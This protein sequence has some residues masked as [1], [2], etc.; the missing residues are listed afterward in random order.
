LE[1]SLYWDKSLLAA[2]MMTS[3]DLISKQWTKWRRLLVY[4]VS[5]ISFLVCPVSQISF[6]VLHNKGFLACSVLTQRQTCTNSFLSFVLC[7]LSTTSN[8]IHLV[9][10]LTEYLQIA[11][12]ALRSRSSVPSWYVLKKHS[13]KLAVVPNTVW[14]HEDMVLKTIS[15][16]VGW[17]MTVTSTDG[18]HRHTSITYRF[19]PHD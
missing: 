11:V 3:M 17:M 5:K 16:G 1:T 2:L 12:L 18:R 13:I 14:Y 15:S 10:L 6:T 4:T 19:Y 9:L 7:P 8:P